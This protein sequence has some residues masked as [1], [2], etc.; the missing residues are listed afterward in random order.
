VTESIVITGNQTTEVRCIVTMHVKVCRA[1]MAHFPVASQLRLRI[2]FLITAANGYL[3][4]KHTNVEFV[5]VDRV[6]NFLL[7]RQHTIAADGVI[8][9]IMG[10]EDPYSILRRETRIK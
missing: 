5:D 2:L 7:D 10:T 3:P 9:V 8:C 4:R 1:P 6:Y